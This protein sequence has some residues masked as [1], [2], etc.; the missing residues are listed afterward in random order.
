MDR[1]VCQTAYLDD[2]QSRED[3]PVSN[4]TTAGMEP[5][6]ILIVDDNAEAAQTLGWML[7][8]FGHRVHLAHD[9]PSALEIAHDLAPQL[10]L[11]DLSLPGMSGYEVCKRLRDLPGLNG[12]VCVAQTGWDS[13]QHF[14]ASRA[15][16]FARHLVKPVEMRD[17]R[18]ILELCEKKLPRH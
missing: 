13:P 18:G 12:A 2:F 17:L 10:V 1:A 8:A 15:A 16:G 6:S 9:G 7:E 5:L 4:K 3:V 11:M 14:E